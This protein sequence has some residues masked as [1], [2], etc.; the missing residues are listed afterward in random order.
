MASTQ[1][2]GLASWCVASL[3]AH[4]MPALKRHYPYPPTSRQYT[5]RK[6]CRTTHLLSFFLALLG[7]T[8]IPLKFPACAPGPSC[9][10]LGIPSLATVSEFYRDMLP[11]E[12]VAAAAAG[13]YGG[14]GGGRGVMWVSWKAVRASSPEEAEREVP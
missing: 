7:D 6:G 3:L 8:V 11:K 1:S 10:T 13:C 12:R 4:W 9:S 14:G 5:P 2:L